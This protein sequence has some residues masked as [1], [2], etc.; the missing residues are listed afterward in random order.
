MVKTARLDDAFSEFFELEA[1]QCY[2]HFRHFFIAEHSK[3]ACLGSFTTLLKVFMSL[4]LP[5]FPSKTM[6]PSQVLEFMGIILDINHM[7][8]RLPEDKLARIH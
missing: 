1:S 3:I 2:S 4:R 5:T 6:G 7:E 8:A